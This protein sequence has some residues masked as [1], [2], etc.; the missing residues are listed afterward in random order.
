MQQ[1]RK[2]FSHLSQEQRVE[3]F[4]YLREGLSCRSIWKIIWVSHTTISREIER[5]SIDKWREKF[6]YKPLVA[7]K[8]YNERRYKANHQNIILWRDHKLRRRIQYL[9]RQK[10]DSWWPDEI[11]WRL[12]KEWFRRINTS[13]L[14]RFIR[15]ECPLW[16]R[17]LRYKQ[18][19]Y[20]TYSKWNKRGKVYTDVPNISLRPDFVNNRER[21]ADWEWDTIVSNRKSKWWAITLVE[22]K[23]LYLLMKKISSHQAYWVRVSIEA[24]IKN[25]KVETITFDNWTEFAEIRKLPVQCYR[26]NPYA[27]YERWTNERTNWMIRRFIPKWSDINSR[28]D[29]EIAMI[30]NKLNHKPRKKLWYLTPYEVYHNTSLSYIS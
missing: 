25:E 2:G 10:W 26:A 4:W 17:Y 7:Q 30:Q 21:I 13:T 23:S 19:W 29:E 14:Y 11:L 20:K 24:M 12:W 18:V 6:V 15:Y 28:T 9:L 1:Q 3:I 16:Q 8:R 22:R 27:S 5:N